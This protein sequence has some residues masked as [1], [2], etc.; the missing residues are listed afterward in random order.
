MAIIE[1]LDETRINAPRLLPKNSVKRAQT[2]AIAEVINSG[3]QPYQ[4]ANV[5]NRISQY[6]GDEKISEWINTYLTRGLRAIEELLVKSS[7]KF[8]VGDEI[9]IA[10]CCLV[11]QVYSANR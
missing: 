9:T 10:D 1:Y 7:G 3:I 2:R 6:Q 4:N 5:T 8:C 11:P